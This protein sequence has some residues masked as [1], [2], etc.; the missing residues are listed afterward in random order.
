MQ[1]KRILLVDD[2]VSLIEFIKIR[3]ETTMD[4]EVK[5][6]AD[7]NDIL[8]QVHVFKPDVI[9]LDLLLPGIGGLE[10][11]EILDNDP[12]GASV[13]II[14]LSALGKEADKVKAYKLG[15]VEYLIKPVEPATLL[16][17]IEKAIKL[18]SV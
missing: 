1:R 8:N 17:A 9:V 4:Y 13:P 2:E 3:L 10:A 15:V 6:L 16:T 12:L 14:I 18:K 5:I 7:A 11:C